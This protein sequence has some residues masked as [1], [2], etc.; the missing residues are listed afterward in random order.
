LRVSPD[1]VLGV[2]PVEIDVELSFDAAVLKPV[3]VKPGKGFTAA[4][5]LI[6]SPR[7]G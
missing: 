3:S 6:A 7:A 2:A 5:S 1:E 4:G